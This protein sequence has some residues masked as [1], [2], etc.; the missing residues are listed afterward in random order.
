MIRI[1]NTY[2]VHIL[3]LAADVAGSYHVFLIFFQSLAKIGKIGKIGK[4]WKKVFPIF[5]ISELEI[6]TILMTL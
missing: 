1:Y 6:H 2:H 5:P 4:V 3:Y